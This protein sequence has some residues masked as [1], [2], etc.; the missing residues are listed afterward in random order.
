[1]KIFVFTLLVLFELRVILAAS[2][3]DFSVSKSK[4]FYNSIKIQKRF[5][6]FRATNVYFPLNIFYAA[7]P[8]CWILIIFGIGYT[9]GWILY[10]MIQFDLK[11]EKRNQRDWH[12]TILLI[13]LPTV[14][15]ISQRFHP[16]SGSLRVFYCFM[17][18][19]SIA[20]WQIVLFL[21]VKFLKVPVQKHQL[22]TTAEIIDWTYR[23][24]GSPEVLSLISF[25][26]RVSSTEILL[27]IIRSFCSISISFLV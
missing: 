15:G 16:K 27:D 11:Y 26:E 5:Y 4:I 12:Y 7:T 9:T 23:L 24:T 25:D 10:I 17:L 19:T 6:E 2:Q 22:S 8:E 21:G 13:A 14:I 20:I 3:F 1:M 18:I